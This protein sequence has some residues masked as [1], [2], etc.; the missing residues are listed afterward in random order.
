[1]YMCTEVLQAKLES[2]LVV[3][4]VEVFFFFFFETQHTFVLTL[5][6]MDQLYFNKCLLP[7]FMQLMASELSLKGFPPSVLQLGFLP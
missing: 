5:K 4:V 1:M 6:I 2:F 3:A 7:E